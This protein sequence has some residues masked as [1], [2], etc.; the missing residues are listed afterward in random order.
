MRN[1]G[2][3][4]LRMSHLLLPFLGR[5]GSQKQTLQRQPRVGHD[6]SSRDTGR[7]RSSTSRDLIE[8]LAIDARSL[9]DLVKDR[10]PLLRV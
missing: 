5:S 9:M 1:F 7:R 4:W 6:H 10:V 8:V 2:R 3:P